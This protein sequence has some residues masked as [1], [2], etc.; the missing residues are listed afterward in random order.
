ML[1]FGGARL[2]RGVGKGK[3]PRQFIV[4]FFDDV[5]LHDFGAVAPVREAAL[6]EVANLKPGD[7]MAVFFGFPLS[8]I[9][10]KSQTTEVPVK[11]GERSA[12]ARGLALLGFRRNPPGGKTK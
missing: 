8:E 9:C 4:Y 10:V 1:E 3:S 5:S 12:Q 6:N 2:G 7:R 11:A